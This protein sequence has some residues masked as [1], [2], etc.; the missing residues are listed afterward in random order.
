MEFAEN[1]QFA[2]TTIRLASND[3]SE[4]DSQVD[5][6]V[7][8][9]DNRATELAFINVTLEDDDWRRIEADLVPNTAAFSQK[10][11]A[12]WESDPVVEIDVLRLNPDARAFEI[13][14]IVCGGI[15]GC[16]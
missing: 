12:V 9:S 15:C 7:R 2:Q 4:P 10:E 5:L 14:Y 11:I 16:G 8:V 13:E 6:L 3:F 1:Q